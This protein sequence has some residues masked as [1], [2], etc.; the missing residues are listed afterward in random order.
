MADYASQEETSPI[1]ALVKQLKDKAGPATKSP[2]P[3]IQT[4]MM[5]QYH[6]VKDKHPDAL[7]FFRF[8]DFYELF[9]DDA[10]VAARALDIVLTSRTQ[11]K[12]RERVP[13]CGVPHHRL[14]FYLAR[15]V[16]Q[17]HKVAIC[18]QLEAAG[19]GRGLIQRE[20]IR[21]VTPGTFYE[22][23][24]QEGALT[25]LWA[26]GDQIGLAFLRLATGEFWVAD[27]PRA[28]LP[29]VLARLRPEEILLEAGARLELP[30]YRPF[31]AERPAA[32]FDPE[33][34][35]SLLAGH[36][37]RAAIEL[38]RLTAGRG[39]RAAGALLA[40][41]KDTQ[42]AF[43]PHVQSPRPYASEDF[44]L[45]DEQ[46]QRNLELVENLF[47]GTEEGTLFAVLNHTRTSMGRRRLKHWL[48]HPL[49]DV[50]AIGDRQA[51]VAELIAQNRV[52]TELQ[53]ALATILDLERLTSRVTAGLAN[54]RDL[55]ALR[56]SLAPLPTIRA[57]LSGCKA[58]SLRGLGEQ[59]D[60]LDD[61]YAEIARVLVDE[62]R[63]TPR[64]GGIIR[65]GVSAELDE[66]HGLQR[67]GS[68]WLARYEAEERRRTGIPNLKMGFNKIFGY[69][70]E[71][72]KSHLR[73]IPA[74]YDRRQT[75]V[76]AERFITP[77]LR[78][79]EHKTLSATERGKE[80]EYE[81]FVRLREHAAAQAGRL[82]RTAEA[83][84]VLDALASLAQTAAERGWVRPEVSD[85]YRLSI[86]EGRHP[87][88]EALS[89]HFVLND[90]HL[91]E[92][93]SF[94]LLTGP[95]AAGKSTYARQAAILVLLAQ[96]GSFVPAQK[97]AIGAV[98]RIFTRVGAGDFLARGLSTFMMEMIETANI[99][100][101]ASSR[102][103]VILDEVGR[104]TGTA[105]GQ[106]IAQAV[107]ETLA[108]EIKAKT[109][110]TTHYH[111]LAR[112]AERIPAIVNARL[113]V[114]EERDE[115]T[116]LY[117]VVPGAAQKS[118]GLYVAQ[119]AGLPAPVVQ[120]ATALLGEWERQE[121]AR[122]EEVPA[123]TAV[124]ALVDHPAAHDALI[125]R[126]RQI[127]PLHTTPLEALQL[128]A[129]VKTLA[130]VGEHHQEE[131]PERP[132]L[133]PKPRKA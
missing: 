64:E 54:P 57:L 7:L 116:F 42:M 16:E 13:M 85:D 130:Q 68:G 24:R 83:L 20:V 43:L 92:G 95:N 78:E 118:Y 93:Q 34:A 4:D 28:E 123:R 102:S 96:I 65:P 91:H 101:Y 119:L 10:A 73:A 71:I 44:V 100:R 58:P 97:A 36:F 31:L 1:E 80:L 124:P 84:G 63:A 114:R 86:L 103:L 51:A 8:G 55:A 66:L 104:G 132:R 49:R 121:S 21:V 26:E 39:L 72:T 74:D 33:P 56:A 59:L 48:L 81:L 46:T 37:G 11:G 50:A 110:F 22:S 62:P 109:L 133:M 14:E 38:L 111:Q 18:E 126:L 29:A 76:N 88:V 35:W 82:R 75:L 41:V 113:A 19:S 115:V 107:A 15:L 47:Q 60:P 25:A 90:L 117:K 112:L 2:Q 30:A 40:Y 98:D 6:R 69:Y 23:E 9:F 106:A 79:F 77:Q 105:D 27:L 129:E 52:R 125:A 67:D 12:G 87:M 53:Q 99:L 127:D 3:D 61:V 5:E 128:L 108:Q 120:R 89:G 122:R 45:L 131:R 94:L 32:A 17:G 70:I